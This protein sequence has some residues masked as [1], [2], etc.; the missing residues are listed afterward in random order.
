MINQ[1]SRPKDVADLFL[2]FG[3]DP[4]AYQEFKPAV[5]ASHGGDPWVLISALRSG[6]TTTASGQPEPA[7]LA[8]RS[9]T[10][11]DAV[12]ISPSRIEPALNTQPQLLRPTRGFLATPVAPIAPVAQ[13]LH[14]T[15]AV[16]M[17][18]VA[19]A[20]PVAPVAHVALVSRVAR[21]A[22]DTLPGA[23][24]PRQLDVLFEH[25]AGSAVAPTAAAGQ[26][27]LTKWRL[28]P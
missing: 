10:N 13:R 2:Q 5:A 12:P 19:H 25:L 17:T 24:A 15:T 23:A 9:A 6:L 11:V 8:G 14:A 22:S 3:G 20:V 18:L 27:L 7:P 26:G 28:Q 16:P 21:T 4:G 1:N